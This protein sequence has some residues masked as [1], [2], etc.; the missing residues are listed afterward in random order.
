[1]FRSDQPDVKRL[2]FFMVGTAMVLTLFV[3]LFALHGDIGRMNTVFKFYYQAWTMLALSSAAAIVWLIPAISTAWNRNISAVW[4]VALAFLFFGALLYPLTAAR[5]KI[6]D[7]MSE[8]APH[9]LDGMAYMQSSYY[10]DQDTTFDLSQ[11]YDAIK[12]MQAN[13]QGSPVIVEGN[14]VEYKWGTRFTIYTGLPG[15]VGW[16]FHE[17]QQRGFLDDSVVWNRIN[18]IPVFYTE[19]DMN[20]TLAFLKKYN[21]KYIIVG[22]LEEAYYPGD[23]LA[24]FTK[25]DGVYWKKVYQAKQTTIYQ[26]LS[27]N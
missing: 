26:V 7:R 16:N 22:Q 27:T 14:T 17:R 1:M 21:V 20:A 5:D 4:Q 18:E 12:W 13:V 25:Y 23:G 6:N 3:E 19:T 24:K 15:V 10:S 2:V 8:T 11:D 9:T